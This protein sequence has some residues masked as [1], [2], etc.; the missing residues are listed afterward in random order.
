MTIALQTLSVL[1]GAFLQRISGMGLGLVTAPVLMLLFGPVEGILIVNVLAAVN[2]FA[3]TTTVLAN[4][5]WRQVAVI[6]PALLIGIIPGAF[7]VRELPADPLLILVGVML[8]VALSVVTIGKRYVPRI[9]GRLPAA[10]AGAIG[11]FMNTLAGAA[12]PAITVYAQA[13]RWD[14]RLYAATLQ[15]LFFIAGIGSL[16]AKIAV[17]ASASATTSWQ[18]WVAGVVAL[19]IGLFAGVR[20]APQVSR[21]AGRTIALTLA[22]LGGLIAVA[23]GLIGLVL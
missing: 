15:P 1:L 20:A 19:A 6:G 9:S 4:V 13:A 2:A 5:D 22:V 12:G 16:T 8:L 21:S 14:Q 23:R 10:A 7:V 3:S 11:G 17:G 18:V